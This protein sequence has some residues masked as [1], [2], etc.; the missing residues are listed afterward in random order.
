[1]TIETLRLAPW[2]LV[3]LPDRDI[4]KHPASTSNRTK[5]RTRKKDNH[6]A[7]E[8]IE[9]LRE[10]DQLLADRFALIAVLNHVGIS[11]EKYQNWKECRSLF[12][13]IARCEGEQHVSAA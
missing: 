12:E 2:G 4:H 10:I 8:I 3:V 6:T 9:L 1:M 7:T 11:A 13:E 5:M